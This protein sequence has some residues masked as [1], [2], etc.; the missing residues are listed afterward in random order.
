MNSESDAVKVLLASAGA[1]DEKAETERRLIELVTSASS[2]AV[3][4][5][6][7]GSRIDPMAV[8]SLL[9]TSHKQFT[10]QSKDQPYDST[11]H[12]QVASLAAANTLAHYE[13]AWSYFA[14]AS[15]SLLAGEYDIA[16]HLL[17]YSELRA[18]ISIMSRQGV[19]VRSKSHMILT[20]DAVEFHSGLG[21]HTAIW[22]AFKAWM[23]TSPARSLILNRLKISGVPLKDWLE[24]DDT[25]GESESMVE[26]LQLA[27]YDLKE[28]AN[29]QG[30]RNSSSYGSR[31]LRPQVNDRRPNWFA[32]ELE[33]L[34]QM[35]LPVGDTSFQLF[36][37]AFGS[38][39][40]TKRRKSKGKATGREKYRPYLVDL[41]NSLS[42]L[43]PESTADQ[44]VNLARDEGIGNLFRFVAPGQREVAEPGHELLAMVVRSI[45]LLRLASASVE[46]LIEKSGCSPKQFDFWFAQVGSTHALWAE[47]DDTTYAELIETCLAQ[48]VEV[49][50]LASSDSFVSFVRSSAALTHGSTSFALGTLLV[51]HN[52]DDDLPA[53]A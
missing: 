53:I 7:A 12:M 36:D 30:R 42:A 17:Y 26:I 1:P 46:D 15:R 50:E 18:T 4:I 35:L 48:S 47:N 14:Q 20:K 43:T 28:H 31:H 13:D 24:A 19:V 9:S 32:E 29:D 22:I 10:A 51:R 45:F 37:T 27:G 21:T 25:Y 41:A 49:N 34:W 39:L 6:L 3:E 16:R 23:K 5:G 33:E 11:E 40:L 2:S 52:Y 8:T 44:I 38:L